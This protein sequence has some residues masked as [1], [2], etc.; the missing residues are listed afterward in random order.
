MK[1]IE[2]ST[3]GRYELRQRVAQ[4][5]MSEVY[6]GYDRRVR[7]RVAVKVL[8]GSDEPFVR[9][10]EREALAV[11]T[12]SHSH[13]LPLY[14]FGEQRPWYYLVM[15]FVEGGTLRDYL[16]QREQISL[17]EAGSFL[18]QIASALQHAHDHGVVHRDVKPSNILL[19][20]DGYA[21]LVDFGL[22]KAKMEADSLTH[23]GAM[24]GT[25]EYMAPEQS[26]GL[27]DYRSDIYSLGIILYQMLTGRVPFMAESPVAISLKHIQTQPTPPRQLNNEIPQS[28]EDVILKALE[29]DPDDRYQ[30][31]QAL[32]AAYRQA[33]CK[34][35]IPPSD[36]RASFKK[37][38]MASTFTEQAPR[39]TTALPALT[40]ILPLTE[41]HRLASPALTNFFLEHRHPLALLSMR[42][43]HFK[44]RRL[45]VILTALLCL[46][47]LSATIPLGLANSVFDKGISRQSLAPSAAQQAMTATA[48]AQH[49][50]QATLVA[51][52]RIQA[53][54]KLIKPI[55]GASKLIYSND[56][57]VP[58]GEWLDDGSQCFFSPQGYHVTSPP[59]Q[60]AWCYSTLLQ[61]SNAI[62]SV[63][64]QFMRGN[65]C[66]LIFRLNPAT[67][68][69]YALEIN[70]RGE[71]RFIRAYSKDPNNWL[72][73]V[74]WTHSDAILSSYGS[75]NTL[76]AITTKAQFL[77]YINNRL[78]ASIPADA[79][80]THGS[81]GFIVGTENA[82]RAEAIFS[83]ILVF[84][85]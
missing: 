63:Q 23:V 33:L 35:A 66:G 27:N 68:A 71:Y 69:F 46:A 55:T 72:I 24:V 85:K 75:I 70:N 40:Q 82:Q 30:Q 10:F 43:A 29:K 20:P 56:L 14:D 4:G 9:R 18:E 28:I 42:E 2:G 53:V 31:A 5:G 52:A 81:V 26:N 38:D 58:S 62:I 57:S 32:S 45:F 83:N 84:Q 39:I 65:L 37:E 22:A 67:K 34:D 49:Q 76:M 16:L 64:T 61:F 44:K 78:V 17:E 12:L 1:G 41:Q 3:L 77:F 15:P 11:G 51:Q 74:D 6:L 54:A 59:H 47:L 36:F 80:Y 7:R 25:P 13:I 21:Y 48:Q 19:R 60:S 8:Y 50:T 73:I 79:S